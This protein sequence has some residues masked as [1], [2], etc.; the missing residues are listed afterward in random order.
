MEMSHHHVQYL[1]LLSLVVKDICEERI[2]DFLAEA[3]VIE[4][5]YQLHKRGLHKCG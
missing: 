5:N 2:G 4:K 3:F 1:T